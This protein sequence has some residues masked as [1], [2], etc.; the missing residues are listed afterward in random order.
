[1]KNRFA[2]KPGTWLAVIFFV[3][4]SIGHFLRL[5]YQVPVRAGDL[6]IP[7]WVSLPGCLAT[8][9]LAWLLWRENRS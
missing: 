2:E 5:I 7:V 3:L 9:A 4:I 8:A 6:S 1:M